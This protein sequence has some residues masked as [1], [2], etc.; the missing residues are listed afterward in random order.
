MRKTVIFKQPPTA[1]DEVECAPFN[2]IGAGIGG[3]MFKE[4]TEN[5][6]ELCE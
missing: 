5:L 1:M 2:G 6:S 4:V 3:V